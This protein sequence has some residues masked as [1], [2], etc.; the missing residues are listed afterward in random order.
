[1]SAKNPSVCAVLAVTS[2]TGFL[3]LNGIPNLIRA[4]EALAPIFPS[5]KIIVAA[6]PKDASTAN[7]LLKTRTANFELVIPQ[8]FEPAVLA[9][10]I[11]SLL[12]NVQAVLIH[13]ASRPMTSKTQFEGVLAAF[14][15]ETDA[16][17]P[18][19]AFTETLKILDADSVIQ[20]TLDRSSVH[21]ISTPELIRVSAIDF[22]GS[23]CG[24]FLPL[25]K[26]ART[27]HLEGNPDGL[28][29]NTEEDRDLMELHTS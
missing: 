27:L 17:R 12:E 20:K 24:W 8:T 9:L 28:R 16:V 26:G 22:G 14:D 25:K 4:F 10:S 11:E 19:M 29:I 13:D 6:N 15:D 3:N 18:V 5:Q 1:M 7:E 23:D 21:R 2:D